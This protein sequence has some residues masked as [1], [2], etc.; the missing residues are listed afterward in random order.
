MYG[1]GSDGFPNASRTGACP[2]VCFVW[3]QQTQLAGAGDRF[4]APLDSELAKDFLIVSFHRVQGQ[5][6]SLANVL[7]RKAL[8][9]E[10]EDFQFPSAQRL[11]QLL[12]RRWRKRR[13]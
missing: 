4:G 2:S 9:N 5:E 7:I 3:L 10:A 1:R 8:R 12:G 13:G 11:D 6:Q